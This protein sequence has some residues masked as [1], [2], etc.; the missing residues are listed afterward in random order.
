MLFDKERTHGV[1]FLR[2]GVQELLERPFA[3]LDPDGR[4]EGLSDKSEDEQCVQSHAVEACLR[5]ASLSVDPDPW[6]AFV[7]TERRKIDGASIVG[8]I[9]ERKCLTPSAVGEVSLGDGSRG[10]PKF[11][12]VVRHLREAFRLSPKSG[13]WRQFDCT[14]AVPAV[15]S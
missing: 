5:V 9:A 7:P 12:P 6:P 2:M 3:P 15:H 11:H 10:R 8:E 14:E 13:A 1:K 4:Y